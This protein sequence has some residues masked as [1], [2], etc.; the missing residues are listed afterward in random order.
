MIILADDD[1]DQR[2][3][4]KL[5]LELAGY[6]VREAADGRQALAL[7]RERASSVLITDIFM[8]E[9]DGFEAIVAFRRDF[10]RTKIIAVSGGGQRA[11]VDYLSSAT[12][13]GVDAT[14]QKPFDIEALLDTLRTLNS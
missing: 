4:L 1:A 7:Q 2:L 11:K 10:P 12:L 9:S 3:S 5:A 13:M 14:L 8:P 6:T